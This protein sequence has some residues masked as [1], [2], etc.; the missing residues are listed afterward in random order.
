MATKTSSSLN[1]SSVDD[2]DNTTM[3]E[4]TSVTSES[5]SGLITGSSRYPA[6]TGSSFHNNNVD[7]NEAN[8]EFIIRNSSS[9]LSESSRSQNARCCHNVSVT[10]SSYASNGREFITEVGGLVSSLQLRRR[11]R[12]LCT[13]LQTIKHRIPITKWLPRYRWVYYA[14]GTIISVNHYA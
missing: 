1:V 8:G 11:A 5:A 7:D 4:R 2:D 6:D 14:V 13:A 12:N 3:T 10:C 9:S